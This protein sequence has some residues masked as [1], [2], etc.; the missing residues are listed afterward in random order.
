MQLPSMQL[1]RMQLETMKL[2]KLQ[3]P[4]MQLPRNALALIREYSKPLTPPDWHKRQWL[5]V[6]DIYK[7]IGTY[8]KSKK[9]DK[10]FKLYN[11]FLINVQNQYAWFN[12]Y[13]YYLHTTLYFTSI[14]F[15]IPIKILQKLLQ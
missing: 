9:Y 2:P 8:K 5:C 12:I 15:D 10:H 6:G 13:D 4:S 1:E 14:E 3:L 11:Q 7:E